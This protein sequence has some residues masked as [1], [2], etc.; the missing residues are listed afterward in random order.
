MAGDVMTTATAGAGEAARIGESADSAQQDGQDARRDG[1]GDGDRA[2]GRRARQPPGTGPSAGNPQA[3]PGDS[4]L[5]PEGVSDDSVSEGTLPDPQATASDTLP[6]RPARPARQTRQGLAPAA[7]PVSPGAGG[8]PPPGEA[9]STAGVRC[10]PCPRTA[11]QDHPRAPPEGGRADGGARLRGRRA[12]AQG[13]EAQVGRPV[14][15][16][17]PRGGHDPRRA[18]HEHRDDLRRA[19]ARHRRGHRLHPHRAAQRVR[20][21]RRGPRRRRH[22]AGQGQV[23]CLRRG[24]DRPQDGG[25]DV[26]R[27]PR[28]GHQARRPAA[29]HAD[30]PLHAARQAGAQVTRDPGDLRPAGA[31]PRHEHG[32]VGA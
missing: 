23:R 20:R 6:A 18:R 1:P 28:P 27:H 19:A 22:Q 9:R 7:Q 5:I 12:L 14:H 25:R 31:P 11:D 29:Q 17:S 26:P 30:A 13:P 3:S 15:H 10:E 16:P 21:G 2:A 8:P 4:P 32:Q 24:R